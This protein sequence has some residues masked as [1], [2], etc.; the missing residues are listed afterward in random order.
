MSAGVVSFT[1]ARTARM[2]REN[3]PPHFIDSFLA[4]MTLLAR[5]QSDAAREAFWRDVAALVSR[6]AAR[7]PA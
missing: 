2:L 5:E 3:A 7:V 1:A 6:G 4:R